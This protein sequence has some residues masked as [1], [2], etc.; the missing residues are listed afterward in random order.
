MP[1]FI[2][3]AED[4]NDDQLLFAEALRQI[5]KESTLRVVPT[6]MQ[7][8]DLLV[9]HQHVL[10]DVVVMDVNMPGMSGIECLK[11]IR[12]RF[13]LL[14]VA[15]MSTSS[16]IETIDAAFESGADCYV[17]KPGKYSELK[18]VIEKIIITDWPSLAPAR[19][20]DN[21]LLKA[22]ITTR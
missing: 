1:K 2:A 13:G 10:P 18:A 19:S 6:G 21:F 5:C 17:V 22:L 11:I 12:S 15:V 7:L 20:R 16:D 8:L 3:L 9:A 4:D 14:P